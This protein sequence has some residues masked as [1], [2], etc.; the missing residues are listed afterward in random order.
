MFVTLTA[1]KHTCL[2]IS[3]TRVFLESVSLGWLHFK[4]NLQQTHFQLFCR[5]LALKMSLQTK[6]TLTLFYRGGGDAVS[7]QG[8]PLIAS[9]TAKGRMLKVCWP[10]SRIF[11]VINQ[12]SAHSH[13]THYVAMAMLLLNSAWCLHEQKCEKMPFFIKLNFN[14]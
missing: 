14:G 1:T 2:L 7:S 12:D 6:N 3:S 9:W 11:W 5:H 13:V 8:I 10:L 4:E